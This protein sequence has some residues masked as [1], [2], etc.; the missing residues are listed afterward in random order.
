MNTY[1]TQHRADDWASQSRVIHSGAKLTGVLNRWSVQLMRRRSRHGGTDKRG[2]TL[3]VSLGGYR[4]E[5][6]TR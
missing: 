2:W 6:G 3:F 4:F 5:I 1:K